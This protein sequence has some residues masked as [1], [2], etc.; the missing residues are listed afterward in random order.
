[1]TGPS[2]FAAEPAPSHR[3]LSIV[4]IGEDGIEGL[5][6][7]ARELIEPRLRRVAGG[8]HQVYLRSHSGSA[9]NIHSIL[10]GSDQSLREFIDLAI[11]IIVYPVLIIAHWVDST[12]WPLPSS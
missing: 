11:T 8:S 2:S 7:G 9:L 5:G 1:M 6:S 12:G 10:I 4:G 3:W